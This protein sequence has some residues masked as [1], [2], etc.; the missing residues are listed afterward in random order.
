LAVTPPNPPV[1][2]TLADLCARRAEIKIQ[3]ICNEKCV[4]FAM[5]GLAGTREKAP[6]REQWV[7]MKKQCEEQWKQ[8]E[9]QG[10]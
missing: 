3:A 2:G 8:W 5:Q 6:A 1:V 10:A 9:I 4:P 7:S